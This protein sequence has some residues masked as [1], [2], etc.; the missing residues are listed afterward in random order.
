MDKVD[1]GIFLFHVLVLQKVQISE[2]NAKCEVI[3]IQKLITMAP[4]KLKQIYECI[5]G[6]VVSFLCV[7]FFLETVIN[8]IFKNKCS[9]W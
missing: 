8:E 7:A 6:A 2:D 9:H 1:N 5:L 4:K 3:Q